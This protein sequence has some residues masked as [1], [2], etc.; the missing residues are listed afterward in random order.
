MRSLLNIVPGQLC[1]FL[2]TPDMQEPLYGVPIVVEILL[3]ELGYGSSVAIA[4]G[5]IGK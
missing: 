4:V 5:Q 2:A 1:R 3:I